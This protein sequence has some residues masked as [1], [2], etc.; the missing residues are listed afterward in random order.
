MFDWVDKR[1]KAMRYELGTMLRVWVPLAKVEAP[2]PAGD[3][4]ALGKAIDPA[5]TQGLSALASARSAD[6][7]KLGALAR[8]VSNGRAAKDAL[9]RTTPIL[10][11][12]RAEQQAAP[13]GPAR[14]TKAL[15]LGRYEEAVAAR[16][17]ALLQQM[18]PALESLG[19]ELPKGSLGNPPPPPELLREA[20]ATVRL[21]LEGAQTNLAAAL[22][23]DGAL[24]QEAFL[25][26]G[27]RPSLHLAV[28]R[29][30]KMAAL[31]YPWSDRKPLHSFLHELAGYYRGRMPNLVHFCEQ[32]DQ[33]VES[34][35]SSWPL[36][37]AA[38][39]VR[40]AREAY[41]AAAMK[42]L[43]YIEPPGTP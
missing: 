17:V 24:A 38:R 35:D 12:V 9:E 26:S 32:E 27:W 6:P 23:D 40:Q 34:L 15:Q 10:A 21:S 36:A 42:L 28:L 25:P 14:D 3:D 19:R 18:R 13:E 33:L 39:D 20:V 29:L 37:P 41:A 22:A 4:A 16:M 7:E 43:L 31:A 2:V 5:S 30:A 8:L 11:A 1:D